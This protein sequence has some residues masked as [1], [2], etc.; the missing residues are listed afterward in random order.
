MQS[1]KAQTSM[2]FLIILTIAM[3]V[4]IVIVVMSQGQITTIQNMN[5]NTNARNSLLDLSSAA[6]E[7]YAQG[8][9]S[10]KLVYVQLPS[11][12][13]PEYSV[14]VNKSIRIRAAGTD[15]VSLENFNVRGYLPSS[16]GGHWVWVVSE[17]NRVRI[18]DAMME[19]SKNRIYVVMDSNST[20]SIS[21]SVKNIWVRD[22]DV[23][24]VTTWN[25]PDV[26]MTGVPS[27]FSL[28]VDDSETIDLEF[29]STFDA[30][31]TYVGKIELIA[32]DSLGYTENVDVPVTVYVIPYYEPEPE[33]DLLGPFVV[34]IYQ[35]PTPAIKLEPL[36][37]FVNAS[38]ELTGNSTIKGCEID[39]DNED[40][41]QDMLPMDGAYDETI[42]LSVY[43]YTEGFA[44]GP[45]T[46][47]TRCTD[48]WNNLGPIAYYYFMVSES[49][50]LGPIVISMNHT[51]W[52]TTLSNITVGGTA[53]DAYTG[54]SDMQGCN[55]KI[56][57]GM[58]SPSLPT[59][60]SWDS[61][62][63]NFTYN[64][65]PLPVGYHTAYHQCTD[66]L[67]NIGGIY[68]DSFGIV[69]VDLMLV[70]DRSGSMDEYITEVTNSNSVWASSTG[71]SWVKSITIEQTDGDIADLSTE[72]RAS[73]W[74]CTVYYRA[75]ID[76]NEI[77]TGSRT[78]T[79]YGF[80]TEEVDISGYETPFTIDLWLKRS[81]SGCYAYN[82][83]FS[84][85][86]PP[87][88]MAA[89][90][91]SS[92][93]FIDIAGNNIQAG[94]VSYSTSSTLDE[95][96]KDMDPANQQALKNA[97]DTLSPYGNTCIQCGLEDAADELTSA[98]ARPE[99]NK[100]IVLLTDGKANTGNS[101][102]GAVYCRDRD[103]VVYTIGFGYDVD[104]V[105]LTNIALL[106]HGDYYFAPNAQT[107]TY[108]FQNIGR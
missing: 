30:G 75:T 98:R 42:E 40:S 28:T 39:A 18:G 85:Q 35:D 108:I 102:T 4:L 14:V 63:E 29:T 9:G 24:T 67:G 46:I 32:L 49:D 72:I 44:L 66:S 52:P 56:D 8:E 53:T 6:K 70:L 89:T 69:D 26:Q 88:K 25:N 104:E 86:Q 77:A 78:S 57:D 92:K 80:L 61:P 101:I 15:H 71:W 13:E 16:P 82:R 64:V 11:T 87:T 95:L 36:A 34:N 103:I 10:K 68:N 100:V 41:W 48:V 50:V 107:L 27:S 97:I 84:F 58:W 54:N 20:E 81:S 3:L 90:K 17:G 105:E 2:E 83:E 43:N 33:E 37:I 94:L 19:L 96:L 65:G 73:S 79:Y 47:R 76:G 7:V 106:T 21:F 60:G 45:H 31:G 74:G 5:D 59:D 99:A 12:Y 1:S 55:V 22:F 51:E 91:N 93:I 62:T 23:N 38:D